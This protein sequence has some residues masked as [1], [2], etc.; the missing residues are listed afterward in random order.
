MLAALAAMIAVGPA[1]TA[2]EPMEA[3]AH[4]CRVPLQAIT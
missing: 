4:D 3:F 2:I 1:V